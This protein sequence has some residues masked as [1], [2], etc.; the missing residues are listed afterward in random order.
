MEH[1][2][3]RVLAD[4][5]HTGIQAVNTW[6]RPTPKDVMGELERDE[7]AEVVF[8]EIWSPVTAAGV[9]EELR[10]IIPVLDGQRYGE[11]V[12]LSGIRS[13]VMAP[14]KGRIWA[15][16]L[17]SFGTPMSNNPLLS[18]TLKY[19]ESITLETLCGPNTQITQDYRIRLWGYVY[20]AAELSKVFGSML[21]P[22]QIV[23]RARDRVLPIGKGAIP[24]T[25]ATWKTLPG[26]KDQSIP[27]INPLIRYAYNK[28]ATDGKSGGYEFRYDIGNVDESDENL[29]WDF[30]DLDALLV[31]SI[32]IRA[33]EA[34]NL[35][36]TALK[37]A[38]DYHPKGLIPT[39]Y[40]NNPLHFGRAYP[41]FPEEI[42]LYYAIPKLERPDQSDAPYLIWNEKGSVVVRDKGAAVG[43]NNLVV[44]LTG[45][46][47]EMK[48]G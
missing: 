21:F 30:D 40:T 9:E 44:A 25:S 16:K 37:I 3:L 4:Y 41:F 18:T 14:P 33:D 5:L 2:E 11:Y 36:K 12:S 24:V 20:K 10:K 27:K 23:D 19:S 46:R 48:G 42:P 26:G 34:G 15:G 17:Y 13:S 28:N 31:K 39:T 47:I 8:A 6:V 7:R 45:T 43:A 1:Y 32:G 29:Y 22:T 35:E 38:G